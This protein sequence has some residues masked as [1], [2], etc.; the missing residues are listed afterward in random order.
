MLPDTDRD[1]IFGGTARTV[2]P[3]LAMQ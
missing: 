1:W 3:V 2:Y